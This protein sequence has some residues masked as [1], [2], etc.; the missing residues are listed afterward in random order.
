[1]EALLLKGVSPSMKRPREVVP[2]PLRPTEPGASLEDKDEGVSHNDDGGGDERWLKRQTFTDAAGPLRGPQLNRGTL[3]STSALARP[4]QS[5]PIYTTVL[6]WLFVA[7]CAAEAIY[8]PVFDKANSELVGVV[9]YALAAVLVAAGII[10]FGRAVPRLAVVLV[11]VGALL[12]AVMLV[13]TLLVPVMA[14]ILI[15]LFALGARRGSSAAAA[16]AG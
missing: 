15:V 11:T 14:L 13:W 12:G 8:Q 16:P 6:A 10:A 3:M 7:A 9:G 4:G 2:A 1:M 5:M